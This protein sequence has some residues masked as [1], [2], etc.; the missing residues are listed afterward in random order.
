[1]PRRRRWAG[2]RRATR[3][4][5]LVLDSAGSTDDLTGMAATAAARLPNATHRSLPGEWHDVP[6]EILAPA[7][8]DFLKS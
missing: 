1:M 3:N 4:D 7:V 5:T 2:H 8:R 6:A